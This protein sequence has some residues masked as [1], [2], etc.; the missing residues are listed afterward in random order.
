MF[1]SY[2]EYLKYYS[3]NLTYLT[4]YKLRES[5]SYLDINEVISIQDEE[6][7]KTKLLEN[8]NL[9]NTDLD[10]LVLELSPTFKSLYGRNLKQ[11][12]NIDEKTFIELG[13]V[14]LILDYGENLK[15]D[16]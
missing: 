13:L 4:Y 2:Q 7:D 16:Y 1:K 15:L 14:K 9:E 11:I 5:I 12:E 6:I 3:K 8:N 10:S